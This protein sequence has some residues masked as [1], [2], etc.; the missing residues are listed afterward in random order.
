MH[1]LLRNQKYIH[2]FEKN[3]Q[4]NNERIKIWENIQSK[5]ADIYYDLEDMSKVRRA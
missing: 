4:M 5:Y 2:K 3:Y 1:P